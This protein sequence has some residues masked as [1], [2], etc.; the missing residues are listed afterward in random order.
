MRKGES[1]G[2]DGPYQHISEDGRLT[3]DCTTY[4]SFLETYAIEFFVGAHVAYDTTG[5]TLG[6]TSGCVDARVRSWI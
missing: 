3:H 1:P 6:A 2:L 5:G 4:K